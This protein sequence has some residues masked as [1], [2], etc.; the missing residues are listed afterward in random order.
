MRGVTTKQR[1]EQL[2][3]ELSAKIDSLVGDKVRFESEIPGL[4]LVRRY[5]SWGWH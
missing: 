1:K 2:R 4:I 5:R 3:R